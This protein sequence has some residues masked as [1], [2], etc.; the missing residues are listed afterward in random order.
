MSSLAC[1]W[2]WSVRCCLTVGYVYGGRCC[3]TLCYMY[4]HGIIKGW[5]CVSDI[6]KESRKESQLTASQVWQRQRRFWREKERKKESTVGDFVAAGF[7]F[8]RY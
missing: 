8:I 6:A 3:F 2:M 5:Y 1:L 4:V 7:A